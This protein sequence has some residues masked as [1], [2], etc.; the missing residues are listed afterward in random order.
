MSTTYLPVYTLSEVS[1]PTE[2]DCFVTQVSGANG[3]VGLLPI[4][5]FL[6]TFLLTYMEGSTID[7]DV[8]TIYTNIG[9]G[10]L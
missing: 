9:W 2:S 8:E 6:N 7:A 3:D 4:S 1:S 10:G 5:S